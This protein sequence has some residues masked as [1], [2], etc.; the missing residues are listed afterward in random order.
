MNIDW[1]FTH[2]TNPNLTTWPS[3]TITERLIFRIGYP[4]SHFPRITIYKW[5]TWELPTNSETAIQKYFMKIALQKI[6][7]NFLGKVLF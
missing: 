4:P 2:P 7:E 6:F 5:E 1:L 3:K